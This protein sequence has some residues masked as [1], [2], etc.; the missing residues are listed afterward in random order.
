MTDMKPALARSGEPLL[1]FS[2]VEKRFDDVLAVKDFNLEIDRG[3]FVAIM[4]P[5][6]CGKT[7][8][9]RMLAGLEHPTAGSI[10]MH[11]ETISGRPPWLRRMPL[12]WQNYALFPFLTVL[13]NVGF[14][15][16]NENVG[17]AE[18]TR[19]S[20]KWLERLGIAELAQ[21]SPSTLSGGQAQRVAL[22]RAL[23][24]EPE[25]LLLDEPLS[26]LD[27]NMVVRMQ[28]EISELQRSLGITFV[29]VTH[30]QS[31][32][33]AMAD[34]VVIMNKGEIQQIGGPLEVYR[35]PRTR[36]VAEFVGTNNIL[37]GV[38]VSRTADAYVVETKVG[39]FASSNP[40]NTE[41]AEGGRVHLVV[42]AD[43]V[44][45]G[46]DSPADAENE[47]VARLVGES[48]VGNVVTLVCEAH[49]GQEFKVQLQQRALQ[50]LSLRTNE[51]VKLTF[52]AR[53]TLVIPE[54]R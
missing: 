12:V 13:D 26:A 41:T 5:S 48:F 16:R 35:A 24:L 2:G 45:I 42:S 7:T 43:L 23:V 8:T 1:T 53:D 44:S 28:T 40:S 17:K 15:L 49:N 50:H 3:D 19:R 32:A 52:E 14:G 25:V 34:R 18:R 21:R 10:Q 4:G 22:A 33:F 38:V 27:A 51:E 20:L 30:N 47:L 9:L 37:D 11:G 29:Y 31:E 54:A 6:G 39:R 36:F 46:K